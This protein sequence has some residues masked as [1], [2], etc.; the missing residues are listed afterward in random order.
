[1]ADRL[2]AGAISLLETTQTMEYWH[3]PGLGDSMLGTQGQRDNA[4]ASG[5]LLEAEA[6][7]RRVQERLHLPRTPEIELKSWSVWSDLVDGRF[8]FAT[9]FKLRHNRESAAKL[10]A[11][12]RD[13]FEVLRSSDPELA[14]RVEPLATWDD[15]DD[16]TWWSTAWRFNRVGTILGGGLLV[17]L[18]L[19][20]RWG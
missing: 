6:V 9:W 16:P 2:V 20:L 4:S 15:D 14:A 19:A 17:L 3:E 12:V 18:Y 13:A 1:M 7:L 10:H 11:A 8:D 5:D